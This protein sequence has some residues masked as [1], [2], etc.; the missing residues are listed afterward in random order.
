MLSHFVRLEVVAEVVADAVAEAVAEV[1]VELVNEVVAEVVAKAVA[2]LFLS[3]CQLSH[4]GSNPISPFESFTPR[5]G[6]TLTFH[7]LL[8]VF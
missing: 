4:A 8:A 3:Q 6:Q 7:P 1:V 5:V 2:G